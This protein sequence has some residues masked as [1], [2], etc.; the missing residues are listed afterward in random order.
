MVVLVNPNNPDGRLVPVERL[1]A[2]ARLL[3]V[4]EAFIDLLP[5]AASLAPTLPPR[6]VVLRSFGK[7]YGL[8]GVRLGFAIAG[9]DIA[10]ALRADLGH[11]RS[12]GRR[13]KSVASPWRTMP[14]WPR[15]RS[16]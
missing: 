7:T 8:A 2:A 12:R 5:A 15:R 10:A 6:T 11:G 16:G 14:G 1:V 3:V 13:S 9:P 4:D